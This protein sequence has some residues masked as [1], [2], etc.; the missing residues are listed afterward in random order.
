MSEQEENINT[1]NT[2]IV[3][4]IVLGNVSVAKDDISTILGQKIASEIEDHKRVFAS[5][6]FQDVEP[7][8][9]ETEE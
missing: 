4:N 5:S 3:D 6:I 9:L 1:T 2:D 8:T 7:E